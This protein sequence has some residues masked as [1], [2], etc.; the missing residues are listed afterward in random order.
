MHKYYEILRK[1]I[2][3]TRYARDNIIPP[4]WGF[5]EVKILSTP[6]KI[7]KSTLNTSLTILVHLSTVYRSR[8]F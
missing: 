4:I 3:A 8:Q 7:D 5:P 6:S 1:Y 2:F